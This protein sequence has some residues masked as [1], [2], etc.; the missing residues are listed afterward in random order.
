MAL[1]GTMLASIVLKISLF[2]DQNIGTIWQGI[3]LITP[4][5]SHSSFIKVIE[6]NNKIWSNYPN[7]W[8]KK[9]T[10]YFNFL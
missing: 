1:E 3:H 5:L 4:L 6:K 2:D 7:I 9:N 10:I 8:F